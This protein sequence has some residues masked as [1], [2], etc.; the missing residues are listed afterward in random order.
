MPLLSK[1]EVIYTLK[2]SEKQTLQ[3]PGLKYHQPVGFTQL[4][5]L[6]KLSAVTLAEWGKMLWKLMAGCDGKI[7]LEY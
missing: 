3:I 2:D 1:I 5:V 6:E 7:T 4:L